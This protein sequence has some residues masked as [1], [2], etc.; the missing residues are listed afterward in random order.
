MRHPS[1]CLRRAQRRLSKAL[2]EKKKLLWFRVVTA[3]LYYTWAEIKYAGGGLGG[4]G[5][6]R[7]IDVAPRFHTNRAKSLVRSPVYL[8]L[9]CIFRGCG[10]TLLPPCLL[11]LFLS[12]LT[13]FLFLRKKSCFERV[14]DACLVCL[15]FPDAP[16]PG[17]GQGS[18]HAG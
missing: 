14:G 4:G 1:R 11:L 9:L 10:R 8:L 7:G 5:G 17:V 16:S 12:Y 15:V 3:V 6:N 13:P 18:R 2:D